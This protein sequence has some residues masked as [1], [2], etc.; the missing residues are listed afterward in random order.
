MRLYT[1]FVLLILLVFSATAYADSHAMN[2]GNG[3]GGLVVENLNS[4]INWGDGFISASSQVLPMQ[5]TID[6]V[7]TRALAVRQGGVESRKLLLDSVLALPLDESNT[8]S[9]FF[10]NDLK[11][12]NTLRGFIQNSFLT[13]EQIESGAVQVTASLS[14][15]DGL[16]SIII[17]PT[18]P[19]LSGIA[20][21]L[22][23]KRSEGAAVQEPVEGEVVADREIAVHSGVIIDA[24]GFEL[25]PVLLPLIYDGKG[26]GVYGVFAVSRDS[27]LKNGMVA[28]MV[29][30][31]SENV[32]SRVGNFP[33]KVKPVNTHGPMR[34][35]LIL[36]LEDAARVRA[37]L[38]RK[39]VIQ[40]CAVVILVDGPASAQAGQDE[41]VQTVAGAA[42]EQEQNSA[43]DLADGIHEAPLDD[44]A[45]V[46]AQQ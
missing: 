30:E 27:V 28:Y 35:N 3:Y 22:S 17:S 13:S 2:N 31:S 15:R 6:P 26:V 34:S 5:D 14:F 29:N 18:I 21:T 8:V 43:S 25:N 24:R 11:V 1:I 7:R 37:V 4:K 40:N 32:R 19:F 42:A 45:A 10:K 46:P 44:N 38:K 23:G 20:P 39:S 33:L 16:S 36:S 41:V 9:T 12:L